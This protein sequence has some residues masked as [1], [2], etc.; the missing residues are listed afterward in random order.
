MTFEEI[1]KQLPKGFHDA[2]LKNLEFNMEDLTVKFGFEFLVKYDEISGKTIFRLGEC[3]V[4]NVSF[5]AT[6]PYLLFMPTKNNP[7]VKPNWSLTV[8]NL[9]QG[10]PEDFKL[11]RALLNKKHSSSCFFLGD[12][13]TFFE[14]IIAY[15][16][17]EFNWIGEEA[18]I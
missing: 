13:A 17:V 12:D 18:A 7:E 6:T 14:I 16:T 4:K 9:K 11:D 8:F 1:E 2:T 3:A 5:F 15:E 10:V